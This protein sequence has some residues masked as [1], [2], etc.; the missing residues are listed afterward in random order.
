[1][2][3]F[4]NLRYFKIVLRV[5]PDVSY[6]V[7]VT[8]SIGRYWRYS[9]FQLFSGRAMQIGEALLRWEASL[10]HL[11]REPQAYQDIGEHVA[12]LLSDR[13]PQTCEPLFPPGTSFAASAM[14]IHRIRSIR[15]PRLNVTGWCTDCSPITGL[16]IFAMDDSGVL[17]PCTVYIGVNVGGL[18]VCRYRC[19][20]SGLVNYIV[21]GISHGGALP[22]SYTAVICDITVVWGPS[23]I[24]T[25]LPMDKMAAISQTIVSN[26]FS[27]MKNFL[28]WLKFHWTLFLRV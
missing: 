12:G 23:P 2:C 6:R 22:T 1:M 25:D 16:W 20:T 5:W 24:L 18:T 11:D 28:L 14:F 27:W 8:T 10:C 7:S 21:V 13:F 19:D 3:S 4:Y 17:Q 26:A 9:T 15:S